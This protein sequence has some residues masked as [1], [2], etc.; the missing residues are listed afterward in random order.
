MQRVT[1]LY[2][3]RQLHLTIE[4]PAI[5]ARKHCCQASTGWL[6]CRQGCHGSG[7]TSFPALLPLLT[8][9][10]KALLGGPVPHVLTQLLE[11][12]WAGWQR[13]LG[14]TAASAAGSSAAQAFVECL[15]WCMNQVGAQVVVCYARYHSDR[16]LLP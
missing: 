16:H 1:G 15:C 11:A 7:D 2:T 4:H 14:S 10:P 8:L 5:Y 13:L 9:M 3:A 12:V 6:A